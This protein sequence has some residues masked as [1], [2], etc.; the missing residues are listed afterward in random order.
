MAEHRELPSWLRRWRQAKEK[1]TLG[2]APGCAF[3]AVVEVRLKGL[4]REMNEVK[5]RQLWFLLW[6][7]GV[8]AVQV[9]L[10]VVG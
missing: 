8:V 9:I 6:L 3:G 2:M 1:L 7:V 5:S 4:E 10:K